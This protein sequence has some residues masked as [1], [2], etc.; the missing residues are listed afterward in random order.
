MECVSRESV[1]VCAPEVCA[2]ENA[3]ARGDEHSVMVARIG[4]YSTRPM[5]SLVA[6]PFIAAVLK[7]V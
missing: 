2:D 3:V 4:Y 7:I 6:D 1:S 5:D